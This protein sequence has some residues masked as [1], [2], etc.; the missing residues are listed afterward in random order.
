MRPPDN[1]PFSSC[2]CCPLVRRGRGLRTPQ[3]QGLGESARAGLGV[4]G[5]GVRCGWEGVGLQVAVVG[6]AQQ[7][8]A[9]CWACWACWVSKNSKSS[10][11]K[12]TTIPVQEGCLW[13]PLVTAEDLL[14]ADLKALGS[15]HCLLS[16]LFA[17][18]YMHQ[19]RLR[20][21]PTSQMEYCV[22]TQDHHCVPDHQLHIGSSH[23]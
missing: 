11:Y 7:L 20:H 15:N 14:G 17:L 8:L 10:S 16:I 4:C 2:R 3:L 13:W 18:L 1:S 6:V 22:Y 19:H 5:M 23:E 21:L 9:A 12:Y